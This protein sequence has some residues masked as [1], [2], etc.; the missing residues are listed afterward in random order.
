ML[1][2][3]GLARTSSR[4]VSDAAVVYCAGCRR[5][6]GLAASNVG[7]LFCNEFCEEDY[8]VTRHEA[9]DA[10]I[11]ELVAAEHPKLQIAEAVGVTHQ[12]VGQIAMERL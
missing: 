6:I 3:G 11:A 8:P 9:R 1:E 4:W 12:R 10:V 7:R 2:T 5:Y